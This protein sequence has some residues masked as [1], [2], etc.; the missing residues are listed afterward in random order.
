MESKSG[1]EAVYETLRCD[2][3]DPLALWDTVEQDLSLLSELVRLFSDEYP[4]M[5]LDIEQAVTQKD[6]I[7]LSRAAHKL[8]GAL[9]QLAAPKAASL[10]ADLENCA[11]CVS[12]TNLEGLVN[13]LR[14]EVDS[15]LPV[16][17]TMVSNPTTRRSN[18]G[19]HN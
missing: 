6:A 10:A 5:L 11:H 16:L 15:L 14:G 3:F 4:Q 17:K 18:R 1:I 9:L 19:E 12:L 2:G 13:Q 7:S 8:K